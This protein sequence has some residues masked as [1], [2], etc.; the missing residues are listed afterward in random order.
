MS[1]KTGAD[2]SLPKRKSLMTRKNAPYLF[3]TPMIILFSVFMIYPVIKSLILSFQNFTEGQYIFCGLENYTTLLKD[4]VFWKS[5][6]NTF[7]YLAVQVPVM[8]VLSLVLGVMIEQAFLKFRSGFRMSIFL[9]SVTALV[10]YSI[11]F[12]LLFNTDFGIINSALRTL[13]FDGVDWL[14]TIWGARFAII[15]AITWRWT[16]YNTIIMIAGLKNIPLEL[17]ESADIDGANAFQK[18]FY[19]TIPMVKSIMLFVSITSTIGT[20]QLF[21]ESFVLTGG[22]PNNATITIGHYLY[23][24]GFS[25]YK[26]GYAAA[27]SYAL[28]VIIG[29]LSIIQFRMSKGGEN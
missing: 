16:G 1:S 4:E 22:G 8:V 9:P 17:Y 26:F 13:G 21:D 12:K 23:N 25:Y 20:L 11:V 10:A 14:N 27:I 18:F 19:I 24:T 15:A 6:K 3:L 28:V 29:I 7:I 5:L 2:Y